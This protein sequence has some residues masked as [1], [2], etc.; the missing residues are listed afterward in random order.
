VRAL[1]IND[2]L[3]EAC[4][5]LRSY[6]HDPKHW[7]RL[8]KSTVVPGDVQEHVLVLPEGFRLVF[9]I[10]DAPEHSPRPFRHMSLSV[11]GQN[12]PHPMVVWTLADL[13][14]FTGAETTKDGTIVGS[15]PWA[16]AIDETE[17]CVVVQQP[18]EDA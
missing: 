7:Y 5:R 15:G 16:V 13:L 10:T 6:A 8:G 1:V 4:E 3:R 17:H 9:S 2:E 18:L 12:Y 11:D 14:G